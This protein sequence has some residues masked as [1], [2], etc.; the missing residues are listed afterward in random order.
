M[1]E[2]KIRVVLGK[3]GL[4]GHDRGIR[5]IATWLSKAGMEIVYMGTHQTAERVARAAVEEDVDVIGLSFQGADHIPLVRMMAEQIKAND[6]ED[7]LLVVGGNI[8]RRDIEVLKEM[9]V[10]GV[11]PSA[12]PM[13]VCVNYI[14]NNARKRRK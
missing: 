10:D 13:S 12:T 3:I 11:F 4:D 9:G 1:A 5:M 14:R 6:L 8:P 7:R 2:Q